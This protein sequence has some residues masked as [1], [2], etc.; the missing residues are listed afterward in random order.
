MAKDAAAASFFRS[1]WYRVVRVKFSGNSMVDA[2]EAAVAEGCA[3][4]IYARVSASLINISV[5]GNVAALGGGARL[6]GPGTFELSGCLFQ[7]N[8]AYDYG[9][10]I[11]K[12]GSGPLFIHSSNFTANSVVRQIPV[13]EEI[14]VTVFT[15]SYGS[16]GDHSPIWKLDG[17]VPSAIDGSCGD[18]VIHGYSL[19]GNLTDEYAVNSLY[20]EVLS[21]SSGPHTLWHG[22]KTNAGLQARAWEGGG[23]IDIMGI[24]TKIT[25]TICDSRLR[26]DCQCE[27][28]SGNEEPCVVRAPG[29]QTSPRGDTS[30][31]A[32]V[33]TCPVHSADN[34]SM[35]WSKTEINVPQGRG[36]AIA[37][38]GGST[39][40]ITDTTFSNNHAG[41]GDSLSAIGVESLKVLGSAFSDVGLNAIVTEQV[42]PYECSNFPCSPGEQC[43]LARLSLHCESCSP[44]KISQDGIACQTCV[45]GKQPNENQT[46]CVG[47]EEGRF[48]SG[49]TGGICDL[50]EAGK[51]SAD[52]RQACV[53]CPAGTRGSGSTCEPC[54]AGH[55]SNVA[56]ALFCRECEARKV[57][58]E[59]RI[60][61]VA[62]PEG[63]TRQLGEPA[64]TV[65]GA[66]TQ[67]NED[68]R[69]AP[70]SEDGHFSLGG[71]GSACAACENGKQPLQNR[72]GCED[73]PGG[74]AGA[75]GLCTLCPL[76]RHAPSGEIACSPC[77]AG[78]EPTP[79]R[80][81]CQC[82]MGTYDSSSIGLVSCDSF[83]KPV[84]TGNSEE[85]TVCPPCLDCTSR[86]TV[87]LKEGW[88]SH[89]SEST[90][91]LCPFAPACP[92]RRLN[93][94]RGGKLNNQDCAPG[95]DPAAPLCAM[96]A[97]EYNAYKV[98]MMC[99]PCDD[100]KINVPMLIGFVIIG[101][102]VVALVVSGGYDWLLDNGMLTDLR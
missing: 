56:G 18:D 49:A 37:V 13:P 86:G 40:E 10:A 89:G 98:G 84:D 82:K 70:C 51:T 76:G 90:V 4:L 60:T 91:F 22:L 81:A 100:G 50:C 75:N 2:T 43:S 101:L 62:C 11:Y 59:D 68:G 97:A 14:V 9:G 23:W 1:E 27:D 44:G 57:S 78:M 79:D 15:G 8:I 55:F 52:D 65:C 83:A 26:T 34:T 92:A 99:D 6:D 21:T 74:T 3:L 96:C 42:P 73:C 94:S 72:T 95:Y 66:G 38:S 36:G 58:S 12:T 28:S 39:V 33:R 48:S 69:C 30:E 46:V 7:S 5:V 47:C 20:A 32:G 45:P 29:C 24:L 35:L 54:D 41:Y 63:M 67:P 31:E 88:A 77:L 16:T 17:V 85:C 102:C 80:S 87:W 64:C 19:D 71:I 53:D 25:P 61:C 93:G